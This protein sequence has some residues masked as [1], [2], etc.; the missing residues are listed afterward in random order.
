VSVRLCASTTKTRQ[1]LWI[2]LP[3]VLATAIE[4]VLGDDV[5][6]PIFVEGNADALRR[7]VPAR[8]ANELP[9]RR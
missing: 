2:E 6:A 3:A 7:A 5:N 8:A 1:A 9:Q 4:G